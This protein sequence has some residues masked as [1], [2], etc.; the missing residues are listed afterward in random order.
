[1]PGSGLGLA[2]VRRVVDAHGG[3]VAL[4]R[5]PGG[6]TIAR[7]HL[8]ADGVDYRPFDRKPAQVIGSGASPRP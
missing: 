7:I 8:P 3:N 2:I 5:A 1:M 6:G 4:E